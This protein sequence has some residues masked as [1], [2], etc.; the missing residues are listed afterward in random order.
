LRATRLA[1]FLLDSGAETAMIEAQPFSLPEV[2]A[3]TTRREFLS[4]SAAGLLAA[5]LFVPASAL[6]RADKEA[7]GER[8][9]MGVIGT[10]GQGRSLA[11]RFA[12]EKD[13]EV[14]AVCDVDSRHL[15][16]GRKVVE[17]SS[18]K[19]GCKT[20]KD[21][22]DLIGH[23]GLNAVVVATPDHWHAL[24]SIAAARAG[25]DVYCEKPLTNS[26]GE[27]RAL[28]KAVAGHKRILQCGSHERSGSNA[29]RACEIVRN[30]KIGKLK[31]IR[32][33]LPCD[34]GHHLAARK[35]K[36]GKPTEPPEQLDYEF[37]LGH[38]PR[39]GYIPE[40]VHFN[41]R[42]TLAYGGGEMTD[43]GAHVI[44][45]GLLGAGLDDTGPVTVEAKGV[46]QKDCL[47][48]CFWDYAFTNTYK[49]GVKLVGGTAGPR[50]VKFEG[51]DGWVFI[52]VHGA[53]L[54]A[55]SPDLLKLNADD[56]K[57]K[58]GRTPSHLRNFL[59]SVK[60]RK[61][62][63]AT[64]ELAHRT[65][66]VCHLNNIAMHLGRKL[67]WDP[68]KERFEGD[69]EANKLLTPTMRAPWKL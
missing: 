67:T 14:V 6:G 32:I 61:P 58:L 33:N 18:G 69:D 68:V 44:D 62:P 13:V 9:V 2:A 15:E 19:K 47:Y 38:T 39:V 16:E 3:M 55:S 52:H 54:E 17:K 35:Q 36:P 12:R 8:I 41:W 57:V 4:Q 51:S 48:D 43:R 22:R 1:R 66:S 56:F 24:A 10:G 27:G 50:G 34:D 20:Y 45:L 25:L 53:R 21:F 60:S 5:P 63:F 42:W 31:T 64:A 29:R 7:A 30:G 23:K 49:N 40:R 37:W 59:E 26:I 46:R 65:A 11:S 28:C